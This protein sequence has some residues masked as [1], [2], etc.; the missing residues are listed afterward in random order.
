VLVATPFAQIPGDYASV[1]GSSFGLAG[2]F[3]GVVVITTILTFALTAV[4]L[5]IT[6]RVRPTAP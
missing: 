4:A 6:H 1:L 2:A 3:A 5:S